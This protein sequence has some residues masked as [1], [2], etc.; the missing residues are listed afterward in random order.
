[1]IWGLFVRHVCARAGSRG[2]IKRGCTGD[3]D[4]LL[5]LGSHE[6]LLVKTGPTA[7]YAIQVIV[8]FVRAVEGDVY[9]GVVR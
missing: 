8:D 5:G 7:F 4:E 9:E 3:A 6:F 1:M 2:V